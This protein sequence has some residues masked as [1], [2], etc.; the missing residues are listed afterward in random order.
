MTPFE[1]FERD[2]RDTLTHLH[3][4]L[5]EPPASLWAVVGH[6]P[7]R[8]PT[9]VQKSIVRAIGDLA[10]DEQVPLNVPSRR[11]HDLLSFRYIQGLTQ[12]A[13][14]ERLGIAPRYLRDIQWKAVRALALLLWEHH[15][16][17][18]AS[19]ASATPREGR[20]LQEKDLTQ[21]QS[22]SSQVE[23]ELTHLLS[24]APNMLADVG[25]LFRSVTEVARALATAHDTPL[26]I[27]AARSDLHATVHPSILR[28]V[29]LMAMTEIARIE[30][31]QEIE[32]SAQLEGEEVRITVAGWPTDMGE[33]AD[34]S[35][36]A[37]LVTPDNGSVEVK[38]SDSALSI[39]ISLSAA[40]SPE[41]RISV[42]VIEDNEDLV[43]FYRS[44]V[45]GSRYRIVHQA[46]GEHIFQAIEECEPDVI[47]LDVMFPNPQVDGW[48][49]LIQLHSH[50]AT[51][52]IPVI[53]CS[54][55]RQEELA[56][57]LGAFRYL[58]KPVRRQQFLR[59]LDEALSEG[60]LCFE[61]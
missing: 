29:L 14:A 34:L 40:V 16:Q 44:Y 36:I 57:T 13:A 54:V 5:Y 42:L 8:S 11:F 59:A 12:E 6:T 20:P 7:R 41:D 28:Q 35:L 53:V 1:E 32:L 17:A 18:T 31:V 61:S 46:D 43:T 51:R 47:V 3:D 25:A 2:L 19:P 48:E 37:Q 21:A 56:L 4:P 24:R 52:S 33:S 58:S 22:W 23:Q 39:I 26:K 9:V 15:A 60:L 27:S 10:P 55:I 50:P 45:A 30:S 38:R 49:L